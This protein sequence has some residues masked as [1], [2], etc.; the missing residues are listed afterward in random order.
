MDSK[1]E[2]EMLKFWKQIKLLDLLSAKNKRNKK[3]FL[4]DGPP[5]ANNVPHVGHIRNTVYKDAVI[6]QKFMQ[7][8]NVFFQ[9]GFDT[10]GLPVENIV[11]HE[12]KLTSK[13][14]IESIG[15]DKFVAKCKELA[16]INKD[17]W[18][19]VYDK[20]GSWYGWKAPY[21]TYDNSYIESGWWTFKKMWDNALVYEGKR[22]VFWCPRCETSLAGY[23]VTDSYKVVSDPSIYIKFPVRGKANEFLLAYTT[24]PWTLISN[25]AVVAHPEEDYVKADTSNGILILAKKRLDLLAELGIAYR[26]LDEFK[27][28]ALDQLEYEPLINVEQQNELRKVPRALK[29]YLS[30]PLLKE[31]IGS[32]VAA[33]LGVEAGDLYEHFVNVSE[34]TGLV[35]CAPGH[36]K[37]DNEVGKHYQL[38]ELSPLDNEAKFT[39][40]AGKYSGKFVKAAD[41]EIIEDL[42]K[43][44]RL[45]HFG[46]IE[47]SYPLCWRCKSP[48]IF[49]MSTQWFLKIE[50]IKKKMIAENEKVNW[51]PHFAFERFKNWVENAEDW[52][53][54]RQ[55]YWG[56]PIPI[57]HCSKCNNKKI[58]GSFEEL[59]KNSVEE[60][61]GNF[62]LHNASSV[63]FKC[64]CG[65]AMERVK[66]IFDVW[67]DS[68]I[69]PWAFLGYPFKNKE[70]FEGLYPTDRINESQD[71]IRGW[72]YSL[73]FCGVAAFGKAPYLSVSMPGWVVDDKGEKMSK[74]LGNVVYAKDAINELSADVLRFYMFWDIAP[75]ELQRFSKE[76]A[77]K[78]VGKFFNVF[79]NLSRLLLDA[80]KIDS[81]IDVSLIED[82]WIISRLNS[83][84]RE[85]NTHFDK[86]EYH[87][88]G[89][90][91][92]NFILNDVSRTY[93]QLVRGRIDDGDETPL[94]ILNEIILVTCRSLVPISPFTAESVYQSLKKLNKLKESVHLED[95]PKEG[96]SDKELELRMDAAGEIIKGVLAARDKA[97][98][99]LKWPLKEVII[100]G[101]ARILD[102]CQELEEV[103]KRQCNV[104]EIS[105][106]NEFG[107]KK[108]VK[109]DYEKLKEFGELAPIII[110]RI[111]IES[112]GSIMEHLEKEG[113][114]RM[115]ANNMEVW[116]R[117]EHFIIEDDLPKIY[118]KADILNGK[119]FINKERTEGLDAEG[120][121]RELVRRV[122][123]GRKKLGLTKKDGII[124]AVK[125]EDYLVELL[126]KHEDYIKKKCGAKSLKISEE[127]PVRKLEFNEKDKIKNFDV[128]I[129]VGKG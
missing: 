3:F 55:R 42:E 107:A 109:A 31:R 10:H 116:L 81:G 14:D 49:R 93:I 12:L 96:S 123:N 30:M 92:H 65:N 99:G 19:E 120:Y 103:I 50:P 108:K 74:S 6:R 68:G 47:H 70:L 126:K 88:C 80:D 104:K 32:K 110:S 127:G 1:Q 111:V 112:A 67:Y 102:A 59:K 77:K 71:Q 64:A 66:D 61:G 56:I 36:G 17:L 45:L 46:K 9:P 27:G 52:N 58:I 95:W 87:V 84:V 114:Y 73:M 83:V 20:L 43:N 16:T 41:K 122:Q 25:V 39:S 48:L 5:Y 69:A 115:K 89:R 105:I 38:P 100:T 15:A 119:V 118:E 7:G 62:D 28:K 57:W 125:T 51:L 75:Y 129:W 97:Q 121:A 29:V 35:H 24:T 13:K 85:F 117:K 113:K 33:K 98:I 124:L 8:F 60:I 128:E 44:G 106:R 37:T 91:L 90:E 18:L 94:R 72:F 101:D 86:F 21:L 40:E 23:E 22:P 2:L 34:G 78:E 4:L 79:V 63:Y 82:K 53:I 26:V 54:S 11:E 76:I